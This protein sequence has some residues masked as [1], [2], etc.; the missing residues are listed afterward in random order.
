MESTVEEQNEA[1]IAANYPVAEPPRSFPQPVLTREQWGECRRAVEAGMPIREAAQAFGVDY[2]AV[3]KRSLREQWLT[4]ARI[5]SKAEEI[6]AK[7]SAKVQSLSPSVP[8]GEKP[9]E[10][11]IEAISTSFEGYRSRTL[12]QLAKAAENGV[13]RMVT[14]DLPVESWQD[15]QIAANIA[16]KLHNVGQE[17]VNVNVLVGGDGGFDGPVIEVEGADYDESDIDD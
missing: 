7:E 14:A 10:T 2:E 13:K 5:V 6:L 15:A 11:A 16:M 4:E 12:L 3:R 17:G 1:E 8:T 9:A